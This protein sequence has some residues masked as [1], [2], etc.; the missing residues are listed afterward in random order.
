MPAELPVRFEGETWWR[1]DSGPGEPAFN[2][3]LDEALLEAA[4]QLGGPL[5]RFYGWTAPAATFGY[6]QRYADV[7]RLTGLRPLIRRPTGGG[8]APHERDWTYSLGFPPDHA[9]YGLRARESYVRLHDWLQRALARLGVRTTLAARAQ[10]PAPGQCFVGAEVSDL[11]W[12]GVKI[13]GAAQRRAR[14]GLLIQ[15]SVQPRSLQLPRAA[16]QEAMCAAAQDAW[17]VS[18]RELDLGHECIDRAQRLAREKYSQD[19]FNRRR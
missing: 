17:G 2:M 15:G 8:L 18:W 13:A 10:H 1:L 7:E 19:A 16:W 3:A 9:W 14:A 6:F 5:L 12:Q 4:A 11:L